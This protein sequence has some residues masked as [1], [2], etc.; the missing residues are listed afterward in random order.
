MA[1]AFNTYATSWSLNRI[2]LGIEKRRTSPHHIRLIMSVVLYASADNLLITVNRLHRSDVQYPLRQAFYIN[3]LAQSLPALTTI[4]S[5]SV[6]VAVF[7]LA[8]DL[9]FGSLEAKPIMG[10]SSL[11]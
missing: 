6:L 11:Q 9:I 7:P 8:V 2:C 3:T 5:I 1:L 4:Y 10:L